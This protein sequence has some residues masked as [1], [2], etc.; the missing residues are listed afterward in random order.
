MAGKGD[1]SKD[2]GRR[3]RWGKVRRLVEILVDLT[4]IGPEMAYLVG[5]SGKRGR[6]LVCAV[7]KVGD[8]VDRGLEWVA[9]L[10]CGR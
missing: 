5:V 9:K 6:D 2:C 7:R 8:G 10:M 4:Q 3:E 1:G